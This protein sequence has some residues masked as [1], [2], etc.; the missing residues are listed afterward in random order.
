MKRLS[1]RSRLA[2]AYTIGVGILIAFSSA[3]LYRTV[4]TRLEAQLDSQI[5]ERTAAI[6]PLFN[7][8]NDDVTWL[9]DRQFVDQSTVQVA[10]AIY[11]A[12]GN[13][14]DGSPLARVYDLA[15][16]E[17]ATRA[18]DSRQETWSIIGSEPGYRVRV[19]YTPI[20][21][22]DG[23]VY[24]LVVGMLLD[25]LEEDLRQLA[26]SMLTLGPLVLVCGGL[27][28]WWF[29]QGALGPVAEITRA[30]KRIS[31]SHLSDRLPLRG[32]NDELDGLSGQLNEMIARL[33]NSF[34]QMG[35]FISNVSH[36]LRTPLAAIRGSCEIALRTAKSEGEI[37]K[38]LAA[39]IEELDRLT[40][41]V[42]QLLAFA[43]A[44]A[45][46][47][48]LSFRAE[49]LSELVADAVESLRVL[50]DERGVSLRYRKNEAIVAEVDPQHMLRALINLLDNAIK[51]NRPG[52]S[53][54]VEI[55]S[56]DGLAVVSIVDTGRGIAESDLPHV[57][58]RFYRGEIDG[59]SSVGGSGLGLGLARWV[60]LA[61]GGRI[62][63]SSELGKGSMFQ[64][65]LP[66]T[67]Q[68]REAAP[69]A[70]SPYVEK[71]GLESLQ[72]SSDL[73]GVPIMLKQAA[74]TCYWLGLVSAGIAL[75]WRALVAVG[76]ND[77]IVYSN[78]AFGYEGFFKGAVLLLLVAIATATYD[79]LDK[80]RS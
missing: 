11:S 68:A 7:V 4:A 47:V 58:D 13:Y 27:A 70:H 46:Q 15:L 65:S 72:G 24:M 59:A 44:E 8:S 53:V 56:A 37:R 22:S 14:L 80:S 35:Q 2:L 61:H 34:D 50:A 63:A 57:F 21:G 60:A 66:R 33:Q 23:Q 39:N 9:F 48:A 49:N 10:Y 77:K 16:G 19:V 64:L 51:Y 62:D 32:T 75:A 40:Q 42:S 29:A 69:A 78:R 31:A 18:F 12:R 52:G 38:V 73:K 43:R 54:D 45:G 20:T 67:Q 25:R 55:H 71:A 3:A 28:G 6:R 79:Q 26:A 17:A 30:T 1:I 76:F 36:E 41:T 74:R 5:Q